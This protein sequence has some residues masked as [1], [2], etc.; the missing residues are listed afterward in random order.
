[1]LYE[2]ITGVVTGSIMA[3]YHLRYL[4]KF[5]DNILVFSRVIQKKTYVCTCT[6]SHHYRVDFKLRAFYHL[7]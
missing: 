3:L 4:L 7:V 5:S 6:E 1:M 2:V